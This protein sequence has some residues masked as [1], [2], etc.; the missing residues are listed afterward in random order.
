MHNAS[1]GTKGNIMS[2]NCVCPGCNVRW[3]DH[4]LPADA[5]EVRRCEKCAN[6]T[7]APGHDW[8]GLKDIAKSQREPWKG[9]KHA[10]GKVEQRKWEREWE[11][12]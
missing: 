3:T 5:I 1:I 7:F 8:K 9:V 4:D 10:L 2:D 12:L 11:R 6:P